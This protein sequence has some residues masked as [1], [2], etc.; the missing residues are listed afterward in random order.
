MAG[1]P[2]ATDRAGVLVAVALLLDAGAAGEGDVGE[3]GCPPWRG[4][5]C[6]SGLGSRAL[7]HILAEEAQGDA[8]AVPPKCE[9]A[10]RFRSTNLG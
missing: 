7:G 2:P 3:R 9:F 1:G 6:V 10:S 5:G 4:A 8:A